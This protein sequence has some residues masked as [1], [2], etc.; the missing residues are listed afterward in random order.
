MQT[1][2][3]ARRPRR[4][5]ASSP[6]GSAS[7][8]RDEASGVRFQADHLSRARCRQNHLPHLAPAL[9]D[10]AQGDRP[11]A[12]LGV[13]L[14]VIAS[15]LYRLMARR[16]R[17][18][19]DAQARQIFR[20]LI[21]MPAPSLTMKSGSGSTAAPICPLSSPPDSSISPSLSAGGTAAPSTSSHSARLAARVRPIMRRGNQG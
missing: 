13:A 15:G 11:P 2:A 18:Y 16:M 7:T 6:S 21:D 17:G 10:F 5:F 8:Q 4:S 20:D 12:A 9:T 14:L 3:R 19:D 1:S